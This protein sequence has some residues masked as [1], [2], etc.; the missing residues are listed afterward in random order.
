[1]QKEEGGLLLHTVY[2]TVERLLFLV[3]KNLHIWISLYS[4]NFV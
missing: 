4:Y 3:K 1:M 2:T